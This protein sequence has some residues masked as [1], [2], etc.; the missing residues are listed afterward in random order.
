MDVIAQ[1]ASQAGTRGQDAN[2][3]VAERC[4]RN[5][6]LIESVAARLTDK[7]ARLVGDCA[8]VM[9]KVAEHRPELI[10]PYARVLLGL[11]AHKNG[12]VRWESAHAIGLV[13]P[14]IPRVIAGELQ[15]LGEIARRDE[16]VIVRDYI[17]DALVGYAATG[18]EAA[19]AVFP[20]LLECASAWHSK[21]AAR[22]LR[23]LEEVAGVAPKLLDDMRSFAAQL[24]A[25]DRPGVRKAAKALLK[26]LDAMC[27]PRSRST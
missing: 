24:G 20:I 7:N 13:S 12:R 21:H 27:R 10:A 1:L 17:L 16:S 4:V 22:I 18:P 5:P 19:A 15:R 14:L 26:K 9:T 6:D 8:E 11:L 2:I 3:R 23:G 25:H